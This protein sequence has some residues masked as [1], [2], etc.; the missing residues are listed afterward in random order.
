VPSGLHVA[1]LRAIT[2]YPPSTIYRILRTLVGC[3][4][5]HHNLRGA[6]VLNL[7]IIHAKEPEP[8]AGAQSHHHPIPSSYRPKMEAIGETSALP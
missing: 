3:G 8:M 4:Y 1:E 2:K 7:K 5:L 6:Y